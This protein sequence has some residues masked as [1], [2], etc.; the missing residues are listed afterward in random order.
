M[1]EITRFPFVRHLRSEPSQHILRYRK[2]RL[3]RGGRGLS[4]WF[5][6]LN[7]AIASV[8]V[9]NL[10]L[11]FLFAG[12]S[13]DFQEINVQG[14]I[15]YQVADPVQ[16]AERVDFSIDLATGVH[17][18]KPLERIAGTLTELAQQLAMDFMGANDLARL[19]AS[20]AEEI[21][22]RIDD[23]LRADQGLT[24]MALMIVSVRV[25]SVTPSAEVEKALRVP[26]RESIQQEADEATFR[27]RAQAVEKERAIQ[28]NELQNKIELAKREQQFIEQKGE[29]ERRRVTDETQAAQIAAEGQAQRAELQTRTKASEIKAVEESRVTAE[30]DRMLIYRDFPADRLMA[31]AMQELAGKLK[32]IDRVTITPDHVGSILKQL[33]LRGMC[34]PTTGALP[35]KEG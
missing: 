27:R 2:G 8:P 24:G 26:V 32:G 4:F 11:A 25:S 5:A 31:L 22:R 20:G 3:T 15:T 29:N 10:D 18:H 21:R 23:G 12:R 13:K 17:K 33:G 16:I 9:E 30:R 35:A 28:E 1:A 6:P 7:A 34:G 14:V 19:L